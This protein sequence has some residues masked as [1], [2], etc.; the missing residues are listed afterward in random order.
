MNQVEYTQTR[1]K[2]CLLDENHLIDKKSS[3][4]DLFGCDSNTDRQKV[5]KLSA[6]AVDNAYNTYFTHSA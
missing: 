5:V 1:R 4:K 2:G 3:C 6:H